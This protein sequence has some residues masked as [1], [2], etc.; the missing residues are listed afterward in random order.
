[1]AATHAHELGKVLIVGAGP[2]GLVLALLLGKA[3]V[4]VEIVDAAEK[5]DEQPRATHYNSPATHVLKRAGVLDEIRAAAVI[6][7]RVVWRKPDG[8]LLGALDYA[9]VPEESSERMVALPLNEVSKIVLRQLQ[10]IPAVEIKWSHNVVDVGQNDGEA[11]VDVETATGKQRLEADYVIGCDGA[12][13]KVRRALQGDWHFPGKTWAEQI[14][15]TNVYYDF[16][17]FGW[18]DANFI[19]EPE[20]WF[21]AS[22]I[23]KDGLW[24]VSYGETS[25]LTREQYLE[26]QPMKFE[27]MLPGNPKPDAYKIMNISPYKI[28]QRCAEKLRVGRFIIAADAAHLCNPFGGLG[29]TGGLADIESLYDCLIGI[30]EGKAQ[31]SI[32]D[33]YDEVR[34]EMWHKFID[35]ISSENLRRLNGQDPEKAR[36]ND[37]LLQMLER[38]SRDPNLARTMQLVSY[39][40]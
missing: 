7:K 1:M 11:W 14:V 5:L 22:R 33:K 13:S 24:R 8:T 9:A 16:D 28:H 10:S 20:N 32:L 15:A 30:H 38:A 40:I 27:R 23:S 36:E 34:R 39:T 4:N 26:R 3:G 6:C 37:S 29:L 2:S 19:I 17:K 12:N 25:G 21:M 31:D 35:P 18:D